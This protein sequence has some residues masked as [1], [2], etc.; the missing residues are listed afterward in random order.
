MLPNPW[1][2]ALWNVT[3]QGRFIKL[4]G[5]LNAQRYAKEAGTFVG[6]PKPAD[7]NEPRVVNRTFIRNKTI[8]VIPGSSG[9]GP[10]A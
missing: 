2:A 5:M 1:S 3:E 9:S 4:N 6:G 8:V 7:P 10:P